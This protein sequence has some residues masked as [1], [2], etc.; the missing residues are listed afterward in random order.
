MRMLLQSLRAQPPAV[1]DRFDADAP[2][3][4]AEQ[5]VK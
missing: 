1:F 2:A 5:S 4:N 3:A